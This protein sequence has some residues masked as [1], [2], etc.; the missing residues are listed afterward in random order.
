MS[1]IRTLAV[2]SESAPK[3]LA[4]A[5][6]KAKAR[7]EVTLALRSTFWGGEVG[8]AADLGLG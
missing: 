2:A 1:V 4:R 5:L 3:A 8:A 7:M 6:A